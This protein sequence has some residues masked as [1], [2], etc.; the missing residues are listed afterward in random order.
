MVTLILALIN[1]TAPQLT[2]SKNLSKIGNIETY[3][4]ELE[5]QDEK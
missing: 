1:K 4:L 5:I 2:L 3:N